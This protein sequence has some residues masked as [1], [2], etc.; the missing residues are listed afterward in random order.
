MEA[1]LV[2]V[3]TG[4][5][6]VAIL[7]AAETT[8]VAIPMGMTTYGIDIVVK[9]DAV[10]Y[11]LW[12]S[13][14]APAHVRATPRHPPRKAAT[15]HLFLLSLSSRSYTDYVTVV[16]AMVDKAAIP[17]EEGMLTDS[18]DTLMEAE[19]LAEAREETVCLTLV[20]V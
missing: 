10:R 5:I 4:T 20:P 15:S 14:S 8:P 16:V 7:K 11:L 12:R 18:L 1:V 13:R 2:E 19:D 9:F 6:T 17:M 3:P